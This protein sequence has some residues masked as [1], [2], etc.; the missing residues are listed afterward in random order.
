MECPSCGNKL[1]SLKGSFVCPDGHGALVTS[2]HLIEKDNQFISEIEDYKN[3]HLSKTTTH[4]IACPHC[5]AVMHKADYN[6]SGII[7]D[8][9]MKCH[10]RWLDYGEFR[11]IKDHKPGIKPDDLL[12]LGELDGNIAELHGQENPNKRLW[13]YDSW[14]G[15]LMRG[16][17]ALN[18]R[19]TLGFLTGFS[20]YGLINGFKSKSIFMRVVSLFFLIVLC[21]L[22]YLLFNQMQKIFT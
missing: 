9:C 2:K 16:Y 12:F 8:S 14:W 5:G 7:I 6:G 13:A 17:G 21:A 22:A 15:G 3:R 4:E 10:Y 19:R 18:S 20:I 1:D 11:N